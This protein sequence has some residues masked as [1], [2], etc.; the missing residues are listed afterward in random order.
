MD[1]DYTLSLFSIFIETFSKCYRSLLDFVLYEGQLL[2][3]QFRTLTTPD[4]PHCTANRL[5]SLHAHAPR[6]ATR[7]LETAYSS[8]MKTVLASRTI[9]IPDGGKAASFRISL[10][11]LCVGV[12]IP[13]FRI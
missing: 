5:T 6:P 4:P 12:L 10:F 11:V 8:T 3:R 9:E 13:R 2:H 7:L 1:F